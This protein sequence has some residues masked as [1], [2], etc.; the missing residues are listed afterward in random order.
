[1]RAFRVLLKNEL[2]M[3]L[4]GMDMLIF[5]VIMPIVVLIILG[6]VF[7]Q[8][9]A[10]EGADYSFL[11]QS[12]GALCSISICA[13]GVMGLPLVIS[14]YRSKQILKRYKVTPIK[15]SLVLLAEVAMYVVYA[16]ASLITLFLVATCFFGF[17]MRGNF[18][19]F[20]LGFV[21]VMVSIFSIGMMVGGIAKNSKIAGVI[22]SALYFPMLVFSGA[23]LPYEVMP[24]VIQ[25]IVDVLP[26]T[27]GIKILKNTALGLPIGDVTVSVII[28]LAIAAICGFISVK[29]FKWE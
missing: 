23:T 11:D 29:F 22:A 19:L 14:D 25:K 12:F 6:I 16:V 21:L 24:E 15:P 1:M 7:G 3:S 2:K 13:G 26:L 27:Q 9:P 18:G 5:T 10:F 28:M 8:K 4:R 20:L 17:R